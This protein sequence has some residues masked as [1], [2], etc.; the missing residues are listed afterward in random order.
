MAVSYQLNSAATCSGRS[1]SIHWE[2]ELG[3]N[4][5]DVLYAKR[6]R[7]SGGLMLNNVFALVLLEL[8]FSVNRCDGG[9]RELVLSTR[10]PL[11]IEFIGR[12]P[13]VKSAAS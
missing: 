2:S 4:Q 5:I 8:S 13:L 9:R 6:G 10:R 12:H 3:L 11:R 7:L 1:R